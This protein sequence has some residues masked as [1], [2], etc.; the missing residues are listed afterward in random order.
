MID[1]VFNG[2]YGNFGCG[3]RGGN[4]VISIVKK[5]KAGHFATIESRARSTG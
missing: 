5:V 1:D 4:I 3:F 2:I